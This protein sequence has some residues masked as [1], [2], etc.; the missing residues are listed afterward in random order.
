MLGSGDDPNIYFRN[1]K[2]SIVRNGD[3]SKMNL[4]NVL[5]SGCVQ[6]F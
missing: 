2:V 6:Y 5:L 1:L 4:H 3:F